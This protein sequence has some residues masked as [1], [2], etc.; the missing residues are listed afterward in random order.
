MKQLY[1]WHPHLEE[2]PGAVELP[3]C[4]CGALQA[5]ASA[6]VFAGWGYFFAY[7]AVHCPRNFEGQSCGKEHTAAAPGRLGK[8]VEE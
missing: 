2:D 6:H 5:P 8:V 7:C 1:P 4:V 3:C